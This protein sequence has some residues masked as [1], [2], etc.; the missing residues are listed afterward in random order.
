MSDFSLATQNPWWVNV[1]KIQTDEQIVGVENSRVRWDPRIIYTFDLERDAVYTLR[2]PRQV[3]KTTAVKLLIKKMLESGIDPRRVFY[4]TCDL[5]STPTDLAKLLGDYIKQTR[6]ITLERLYLFLDEVSSIR[7]WQKAVKYLHDTGDLQGCTLLLTGSHSLDLRRAAERL[8]G[9]RGDTSGP[10]DKILLPMKFCEYVE[11]RDRELREL[12]V[13]R[14]VFHTERRKEI[15]ATL[16]HGEIPPEMEELNLH[17]TRLSQLFDDYLITGGIISA[18]NEY[19]TKGKIE[20]GLYQ[21][22]VSAVV[23]DII[24]W[25]KK[26][27]YLAAILRRIDETAT[28]RVSWNA[29]KRDTDISHTDTVADYVD[30]LESSYVLQSLYKLNTGTREPQLG[31]DKKIYFKDPFVLHALA[32]WI[33]QEPP[34]ENA[35]RTLAGEQKARLVESVICDHLTRLAYNL[36]P[37]DSFEP[38]RSVF[39][40]AN[41]NREIDFVVK[42]RDALL[43]FEVKYQNTITASDYGALFSFPTL[44][45]NNGVLIT[46]QTLQSHRDVVAIPVYLFL[47]SI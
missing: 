27:I 4:W 16:M 46:K 14:R 33:R 28:S 36:N 13:M 40:W 3:G 38:C 47:L 34:Y 1:R 2:G 22:Y 43:P 17:S 18:I 7:D 39:Y 42:N 8:P 19:V 32:G 30:A 9:R 24:R 10:L 25:G 44:G 5:L 20:A 26:E 12:V 21:T 41:K 29:L 23:G 37:S 15:L 35:L 45:D 6:R 11:T 31:D